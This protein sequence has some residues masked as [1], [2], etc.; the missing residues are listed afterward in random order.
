MAKI[1]LKRHML[2]RETEQV[3]MPRE[4]SPSI[5]DILNHI[6]L[7]VELY[8]YLHIEINDEV[9]DDWGQTFTAND[10][11]YIGVIP[12]GS[13]NETKSAISAVLIIALSIYTFNPAGL[14]ALTGLNGGALMAAQVGVIFVGSMAINA[15]FKPSIPSGPVVPGYDSYGFHGINGISNAFRQNGPVRSIY[16]TLKVAPDIAVEPLRTTQGTNQV[17]R[18][19]YD[20]GYG[21]VAL[22]DLRFNN[23]PIATVPGLTYAIHR[24]YLRGPLTIYD[25]DATT[26]HPN[27]ELTATPYIFTAPNVP[28]TT[29]ILTLTLPRGLYDLRSTTLPEGKLGL[30]ILFRE[31][32]ATTW[33]PFF[34]LSKTQSTFHPITVEFEE[35]D[36]EIE[37]SADGLSYR[38]RPKLGTTKATFS[39][40]GYS[41]AGMLIVRAGHKFSYDG[42]IYTITTKKGFIG[43]TEVTFT[44]PINTNPWSNWQSVTTYRHQPPAGLYLYSYGEPVNFF[45]A[46]E[47]RE[48]FSIEISN[49]VPLG[50]YEFNISRGMNPSDP[51]IGDQVL[52]ESVTAMSASAPLDFRVPHTIMELQLSSS[53]AIG[54][55][56]KITALCE[57]HINVYTNNGTD[58]ISEFKASSNPAWIAL[59]LLTGDSNPKPLTLNRIDFQSFAEFAA[60]CDES[61]HGEPRFSCNFTWDSESTVLQRVQEVLLSA[62]ASISIRGSKYAIIYEKLPAITTQVFNNT[63]TWGYSSTLSFPDVPDAIRVSYIEPSVDYQMADLDVYF[64]GVDK[65]TARTFERITLPLCTSKRQAW[66]SGRYYLKQGIHRRE[67]VTIQTDV[68]NLICER[69]DRVKLSTDIIYPK[70]AIWDQVQFVA[71]LHS[72]TQDYMQVA[73]GSLAHYLA[74]DKILFKYKDYNTKEWVYLDEQLGTHLADHLFHPIISGAWYNNQVMPGTL[75]V[76]K[77]NEV[78]DYDYLVKSITPGADLTASITLVPLERA[79]LIGVDDETLPVDI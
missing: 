49:N 56:D 48:G 79:K 53:T 34:E 33:R 24:N 59:D 41:A 68:E 9:I 20:F 2:S 75:A 6:K 42:Q 38:I 47:I 3:L 16:G 32:G 36:M 55:V 25:F 50:R 54:S 31:V 57:R 13:S 73:P 4:D 10:K 78:N 43:A 40:L 37:Y 21:D 71:I 62:R 67:V 29:L 77:Y 46:K 19:I 74:N 17:Y 15:M 27:V 35:P 72:T 66:R 7:P 30:N 44:P 23:A 61:K 18:L 70:H 22:T 26:D 63:N 69:G 12:R 60:W 11:I 5:Y 28:T 8:E 39:F 51:L 14:A 45:I 64:D 76:T 1:T 52:I 65:F 58:W